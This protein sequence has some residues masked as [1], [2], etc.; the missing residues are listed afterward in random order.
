MESQRWHE[1]S[2]GECKTLLSSRFFGRLAFIDEGEPV[3]LPINYIYDDD[4]VVFR[5]DAGSKLD[6]AERQTP[7][8]FELDGIDVAHRTGWSVL[9]RGRAEHVT[10]EDQLSRLRQ[11]PLYSW[12]PGPKDHYVRIRAEVTTGRR[13]T[14]ADMPSNWLG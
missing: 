3:I 2:T 11:L 9:I 13:I 12:A 7:L 4:A 8:A 5:T 6:A 10:D 1:L 14:V